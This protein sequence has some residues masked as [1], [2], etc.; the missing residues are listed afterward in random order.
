M[1]EYT[2]APMSKDTTEIAAEAEAAFA[3][4]LARS[5]GLQAAMNLYGKPPVWMIWRMGWCVGKSDGL[6]HAKRILTDEQ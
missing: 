4:D 5:E 2:K 3:M 1:T 6:A